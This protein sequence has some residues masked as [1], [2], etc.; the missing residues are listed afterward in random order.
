MIWINRQYL[1]T[2]HQ[3]S[4]PVREILPPKNEEKLKGYCLHIPEEEI[5]YE[6][7]TVSIRPS[8]WDRYRNELVFQ[9][10]RI[11]RLPGPGANVYS[12]SEDELKAMYENE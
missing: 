10:R 8:V 2:L 9:F 6:A 4:S 3:G 11:N 1:G 12:F 7:K 5:L